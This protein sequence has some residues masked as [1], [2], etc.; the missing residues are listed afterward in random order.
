MAT[1]IDKEFVAYRVAMYASALFGIVSLSLALSGLYAVSLADVAARKK[2]I[3][4]RISLGATRSDTLAFVY[5]RAAPTFV[6]GMFVGAVIFSVEYLLLRHLLTG[7]GLPEITTV[8]ETVVLLALTCALT[9]L[10]T[11][12]K[13]ASVDP[14]SSL[15]TLG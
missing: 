6:V 7:V 1:E 13:A 8:I 14:I 3:A 11:A 12:L 2:E 10:V 9:I 4:L 5:K 15:R